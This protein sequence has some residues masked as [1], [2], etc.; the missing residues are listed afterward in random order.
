MIAFLR[1]SSIRHTSGSILA[2]E[3]R[4]RRAGL[5]APSLRGLRLP[6]MDLRPTPEQLALRQ[7]IQEWLAAHLEPR[8][9][10]REWQRRLAAGG[11]GAP[12][13]PV[14]HGGRG[15]GPTDMAIFNEAMA[16]SGT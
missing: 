3:C 16:R 15:F 10:G 6:A 13:W 1:S 4:H 12:A 5:P 11:W 14:E 8:V 2:R 9:E 7:E